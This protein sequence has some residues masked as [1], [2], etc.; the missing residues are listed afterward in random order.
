MNK[1][2]DGDYTVFIHLV[3]EHD[4]MAGQGDGQPMGGFYPSS[5]W[6]PGEILDDVHHIV[7]KQKLA[8]GNYRVYV[9]LFDPVT[10]KRLP[11]LDSQGNPAGERVQVATIQIP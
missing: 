3:D 8:P 9:G 4:Q 5:R 2:L 1:P 6:T 11:V 7:A 10:G